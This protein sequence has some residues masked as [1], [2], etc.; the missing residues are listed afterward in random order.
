MMADLHDDC[1][2]WGLTQ[3]Q[4]YGYHIRLTGYYFSQARKHLNH[5]AVANNRART[6]ER[7][8]LLMIALVLA[9][10]V[11]QLVA[12]GSAT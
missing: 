2:Y 1:R 3:D 7:L 10:A 6:A 12:S 8:S 9:W 4:C 5:A 11:F